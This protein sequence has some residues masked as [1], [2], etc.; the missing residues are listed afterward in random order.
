MQDN[1]LKTKV[2]GTKPREHQGGELN[3]NDVF[4]AA[5]KTNIEIITTV[6]L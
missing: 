4:V 6:M 3:S 5:P 2:M 1:E